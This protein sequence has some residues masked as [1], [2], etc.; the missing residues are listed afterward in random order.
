MSKKLLI[1]SFSAEISEVPAG[2][3]YSFAHGSGLVYVTTHLLQPF[4][5]TLFSISTVNVFRSECQKATNYFP[6]RTFHF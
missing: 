6:V 4:E 3:T 2:C 1:L 5:I